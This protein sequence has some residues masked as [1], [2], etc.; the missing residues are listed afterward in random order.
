MKSK[1]KVVLTTETD[2]LHQERKRTAR[3]FHLPKLFSRDLMA[4]LEIAEDHDSHRHAGNDAFMESIYSR[5]AEIKK[6]DPTS[7]TPSLPRL[8]AYDKIFNLLISRF[9]THQHVLAEIKREYDLVLESL[10]NHQNEQEYLCGKIQKLICEIG[11]P[12]MLGK[13]L[14]RVTEL[15]Y[16]LEA[17]E[18]VND[19]LKKRH[20]KLDNAF[21]RYLGDLF[22]NELENIKDENQ[23]MNF[24]FKGRKVFIN[25]WFLAKASESDIF[26]ELYQKYD[27]GYYSEMH[28]EEEADELCDPQPTMRTFLT[29]SDTVNDRDGHKLPIYDLTFKPDGSQLVV[30]AGSEVLIY[31]V[32]EGEL[33]QSLKAH[34]DNVYAVDYSADGSRFASGGADKQVVIWSSKMEGI[35]KY[36]HSDSIQALSHNP[37]TGQV[38]SCTS[39]DFGLWSPEQKNVTKHKVPARIL[40][41]SWTNDGQSFALGLFNGHV[42]IRTHTGEEKV[43]IERGTS[44]VWSLQWSRSTEKEMDL[45][46]VT[47]WNQKLAFFQ[48]NG[49]QVGKERSL[50]FDPTCVSFFSSGDFAVV[51]GSD[52]KV[53]LWTA[54]GIKLG[55]VCE[56]ESW[57]W[58]CKVK[59]KQNYVAVGCNDGTISIHQIVFNTVHGLYNERY[60]FRENMTDVVIQHLATDQRAR[61]KCRDYVK[62]IA[63]Y[64]DRL[65]VQL[66]DR[67]I[68]YE[69][70]HDDATDM[71]YRIK[72][73]LQKKLDC[74]LLVVTSQ[75][76]ILCLEK[77]LQMYQF[78]GDKEREWNLDSLIRYIKTIGGPKGQEGLLVGMKNGQIFQVLLNNPFPI[79]L[80]KQNT[81][82]RCLDLNPSR[83]KLAVVDDHNTCLVYCL[84]TKELLFQ[85][86]NANSVAWNSE[87]DDMLCYSGNGVLNVKTGTFLSHQQKMQG[88]VVGFKGSRI[89]CLHI[90]NMTA[91]DVPQST[92]LERY[93]DKKDFDPAYKVACLGVT[94]NDWRRL[95]MDS[96]E[97]LNFEV[98]KK[99]FVRLR[100][101]Q[102]LDLIKLIERMKHDG[103]YEMDNVV[104]EINAYISKF[105]EAARLF[106]R[107]GN[108]TRA[109]QMYTDL[110][111]WDYAT[112]IAS[113]TNM[114]PLDILKRKAQIQQDRNDLLAAANTYIEVG[115]YLQ[116]INIIGPSGAVD[117]LIEITRKLKK[118][119]S[120][121]LSR[122]LYYFRKYN[123]HPYSAECLIKMGDISHLLALHIELMQWDEAFRIAE[124]YPE[125]SPQIYLPYATWLAMN[126]RFMEAQLN[127]RK[128]GRPDEAMRV[129]ERLAKNA[130]TEWRFN[131]ASY[132][133]WLLSME[134]LQTIP[135]EAPYS[136]LS[137]SQIESLS[138]FERHRETSEVYFAF[139]SV[140]K[141]V[142]E[143][144]TSHVSESLLSMATF[145][146]NFTMKVPA[147][148]GVSKAYILY[149]LIKISRGMGAFKL[150]RYGYERLQ[151]FKIPAE[152]ENVSDISSLTIRG[153]PAE[154]RDDL[155][156]VCFA[157]STANPMLNAK[158]DS[159][160]EC[161]E[162]FVRSM[163]SFQLLPLV[164]FVLADGISDAE[165]VSL[166]AREP[167]TTRDHMELEKRGKKGKSRMSSENEVN[168]QIEGLDRSGSFLRLDKADLAELQSRDVFVQDW[169]KVCLGKKYFKVSHA[170]A[171]IMMCPHCQHF[172]M[173]DEWNYQYLQ[174]G[175]CHFCRSK[176]ESNEN[177]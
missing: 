40:T 122:C 27:D 2:F 57:V 44:P 133:Y 38:L 9:T 108:H 81:P 175:A 8:T 3:F 162:R 76:I 128:A 23:K 11:T 49:R 141:F 142:N 153:K 123:H 127:Y 41:A 55:V 92:S 75:H 88:F 119:D 166:I 176:V 124:T 84:K 130:V 95:A 56:K 155:L 99:A 172:F 89:F 35:L 117:R 77:K 158:G 64:K 111:M 121:A 50:G 29:W 150:A 132:Y 174:E 36:S 90:Y 159:C 48:L 103:K 104:G 20:E 63:L 65:A 62:K 47:D 54:E 6:L 58:C 136:K 112:Q 21:I 170:D 25:D 143:P 43:R 30:G 37:V 87:L 168:R 137:E 154:D 83:T 134:H 165:A 110:N 125:F 147:P 149:A 140:R 114:D 86:P 91:V 4:K 144:F 13:E 78:N 96:L 73:K 52:Q 85:E 167:S 115:D 164:E 70:F 161:Q 32:A 113:E 68:I 26:Q 7:P 171:S 69:L 39:S 116:A 34:K 173:D 72:E 24:K 169:G 31:D 94:E 19:A 98:A 45:L 80:I 66:P 145:L 105:H 61:I 126:D 160:I 59:P 152:W 1:C 102:Y 177:Q 93:L 101:S 107:A 16:N 17:V 15:K 100:D 71:H 82:I 5:I 51:G 135:N 22:K 97:G 156:P 151:N 129:L 139:H 79:P 18:S 146:L 33:I 14:V 74:N 118:S 157:C 12:E 28:K 53:T 131:D 138:A 148:S 109:I 120:K 106:K 163:F 46:A 42:S 67:I 10:A 60:A